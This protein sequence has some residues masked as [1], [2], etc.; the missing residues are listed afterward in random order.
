M[1]PGQRQKFEVMDTALGDR[2]HT[3]DLLA[4]AI[5]NQLRFQRVPLFLS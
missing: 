1:N 5:D 2:V 4:L 3:D